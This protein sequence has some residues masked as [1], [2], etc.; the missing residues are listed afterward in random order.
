MG[1]TLVYAIQ[2]SSICVKGGRPRTDQPAHFG[3]LGVLL[4]R[5]RRRAVV[6]A[7]SGDGHA[8]ARGSRAKAEVLLFEFIVFVVGVFVVSMTVVQQHLHQNPLNVSFT[9]QRLAICRATLA[10]R[11][12]GAIFQGGLK[13]PKVHCFDCYQPSQKL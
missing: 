2:R 9:Q 10:D 7:F 4:L 1:Q 8:R 3:R 13:L 6:R 11:S 5:G 12:A